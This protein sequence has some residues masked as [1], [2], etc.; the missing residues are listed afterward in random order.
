MWELCTLARQPYQEVVNDDMEQ[1]LSEGYRLAQPVNCPDELFAIMG[2]FD[3]QTANSIPY[4]L[5]SLFNLHLFFYLHF[6][7]SLHMGA[8][9]A[10]TT[11]FRTTPSVSP[12]F[13][14]TAHAI[15]LDLVSICCYVD[16]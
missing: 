7:F 6:Q 9:F 5:N 15:Y 10:R 4:Q 8:V 16:R 12:R 3:F 13:P 11:K 2:R 14:W 1:F